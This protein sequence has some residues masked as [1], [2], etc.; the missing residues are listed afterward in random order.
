M[1]TM[2][3][4]QFPRKHIL[5][6]LGTLHELAARQFETDMS[7]ICFNLG[8]HSSKTSFRTE[9]KQNMYTSL[10]TPYQKSGNINLLSPNSSYFIRL[11]LCLSI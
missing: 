10:I 8:A 9:S 5:A 7:A 11:G 1:N 2:L 6:W 3:M 4:S